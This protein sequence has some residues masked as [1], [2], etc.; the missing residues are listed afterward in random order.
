MTKRAILYA[1]VST[2]RQA[3][4]DLS[5]PDQLQAGTSYCKQR[6]WP[7]VGTYVD[8]R[9]SARDDNRPEFQRMV[10]DALTTH[11]FDVIVVHSY[12]RYFRNAF[13][14]EFYRRKLEKAGVE[15]VSI[16]QD[17]GEGPMAD[18]VRQMVALFDEYQSKETAK[19]V[20]RTMLRNASLG[21]LNGVPPF[22]YRAVEAGHQGDRIKKRL[23]V[24][25]D[26]AENVK[27]MFE[28]AL[29]GTTSVD[30]FGVKEI[31]KELGRRNIRT[32][33]GRRFSAA[34]VHRILHRTTYIGRHVYNMHDARTRKQKPIEEWVVI[35]VPPIVHE[36]T[37]EAVQ[38]AMRERDPMRVA[39][40][41]SGHPTL[42]SRLAWCPC[43]AAMSFGS[44]KSG[45]YRYY[46]CSRKRR[47]GPDA[48]VGQTIREDL[49]DGLV[50]DYLSDVFFEPKRLRLVLE[51][52]IR[53]AGPICLLR[54]H[55]PPGPNLIIWKRSR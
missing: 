17:F 11:P 50:V 3:D 10:D 49:L 9:E 45:R 16:T 1:R 27:L 43:G 25:E 48:C 26:E 51:E 4:H 36:A 6:N 30:P 29:A 20:L 38:T 18:M 13:E 21:F 44:G 15:V 32:R 19:H 8:A 53:A 40:R 28:L 31:A 22:G 23:D 52:A 55:T 34:E 2:D 35:P 12:S 37:F 42:L 39:T 41:F 47:L 46:V 24:H 14:G 7:L 54:D 5:I 33:S